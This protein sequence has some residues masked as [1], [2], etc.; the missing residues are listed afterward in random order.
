MTP[1]ELIFTALG[2]EITKQKAI[3]F[4][5]QGFNENH[6]AAVKGGEITGDLVKRAETQGVKVVSGQN[7]LD[8]NGGE[9]KA[10]PSD[11]KE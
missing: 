5:A 2:E 4:D 9:S 6:E 8:L 11:D 3:E 1:L 7:Y 10:L